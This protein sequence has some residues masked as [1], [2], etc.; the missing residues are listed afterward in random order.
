MLLVVVSPLLLMTAVLIKLT[1]PGP[2]FYIRELVGLNQHPFMMW[3]FRTMKINAEQRETALVEMKKEDSPFF[4]VKDD[5]RVTCVGGF[6]RKYSIDELPQ[7]INVLKGDMSLVGPRPIHD[8][9]LQKFSE[10]KQL[11]RFSMKPGLTCIWQV[12]GRSKTSD[13][14]RMRY[15][16]EYIN[17]WSLLLDVKLLFKT[18]PVVLKGDGAV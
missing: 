13:A 16:L 7:L 11:R 2:V 12:S 15:D 6:L 8:F 17:N 9:E 18:I 5:P 10:W 4:K 1:S 14:D 3:K